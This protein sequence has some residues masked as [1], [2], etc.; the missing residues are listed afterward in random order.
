MAPE[1]FE[2]A[3]DARGDVYALACVLYQAL[4]GYA[5]FVPSEHAYPLAF[6]LNPHLHQ[7]PPQPSISNPALSKAWD[8]VIA[9]GMAKDP[10]QRGS[11]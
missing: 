2:G 3:G 5:P 4:T 11:G 8:E 7:P 9:R 6:Y 1:R 10:E